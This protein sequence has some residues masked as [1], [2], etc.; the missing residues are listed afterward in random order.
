MCNI[1]SGE[2]GRVFYIQQ[3]IILHLISHIAISFNTS[4]INTDRAFSDVGT[5]IAIS[6][7]VH[8]YRPSFTAG[9][10]ALDDELRY[11]VINLFN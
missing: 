11:I 2:V 8:Y 3:L 1:D 6:R 4:N 9:A 10:G 5:T 7:T